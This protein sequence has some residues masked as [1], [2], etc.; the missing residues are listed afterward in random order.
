MRPLLSGRWWIPHLS[1]RSFSLIPLPGSWAT[2]SVSLPFSLLSSASWCLLANS[3]SCWDPHLL[4]LLAPRPNLCQL[5]AQGTPT[6]LAWLQLL[7]FWVF[8]L[9]TPVTGSL[10]TG[11]RV[12]TDVPPRAVALQLLA[13]RAPLTPVASTRGPQGAH[14]PLVWL[15][16][17]TLYPH[18]LAAGTHCTHAHCSTRTQMG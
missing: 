17:L 12:Q 14:I 18:S 16:L 8:L 2:F 1:A 4:Q 10:N 11:R 13:P 9:V 3:P 7:A 6:A 5:Q 15:Q